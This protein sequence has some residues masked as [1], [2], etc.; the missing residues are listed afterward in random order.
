MSAI[1]ECTMKIING[2]G[3]SDDE[4]RRALRK[5]T[6]QRM[7]FFFH[8]SEAEAI[9][10]FNRWAVE[11]KRFVEGNMFFY[12]DADYYAKFIYYGMTEDFLGGE[13]GLV[14]EPYP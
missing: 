10:R 1:H 6:I 13:K 7:Q 8:I 14:P 5:E 2:Y 12:Y 3:Y 11:A 4:D 9:G